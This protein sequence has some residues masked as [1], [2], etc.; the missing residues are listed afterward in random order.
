MHG[1]HRLMQRSDG[2]PGNRRTPAARVSSCFSA[3]APASVQAGAVPPIART[4]I[5]EHIGTLAAVSRLLVTYAFRSHAAAPRKHVERSHMARC[6]F[7]RYGRTC[8]GR[9]GEVPPPASRNLQG[10]RGNGGSRK[11]LFCWRCC[12]PSASPRSDRAKR[13]HRSQTPARPPPTYIA[14]LSSL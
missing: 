1:R 5:D 3:R 10:E 9:A 8:R 13:Q 11:S 14:C 12:T 4:W 7:A 6:E 2:P